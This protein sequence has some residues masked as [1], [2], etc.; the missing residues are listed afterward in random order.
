LSNDEL[1]NIL[2]YVFNSWGNSHGSVTPE[3]VA[4]ARQGGAI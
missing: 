1:A 4:H 3:E 2:T